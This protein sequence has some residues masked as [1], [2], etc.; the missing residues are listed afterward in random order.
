MLLLYLISLL[1]LLALAQPSEN[2]L[3]PIAYQL[4]SYQ[5]L[6]ALRM[7]NPIH[8][9]FTK[10]AMNGKIK[11][12]VVRYAD[13]G[14]KVKRGVYA[15]VEQDT[16]YL[17]SKNYGNGRHFVPV[18][19]QG[20]YCYFED[21]ITDSDA[22]ASGAMLGGAIGAGIA[23]A[24]TGGKEALILDLRNG[25][26]SIL[27]KKTMRTLL[28][29]DE[30][31]LHRYEQER[32]PKQA[33]LMREYIQDYN[34]RHQ[35]TLPDFA[36]SLQGKVVLYRRGKKER[37]ERIVITTSDSTVATLGPNAY[38]ELWVPLQEIQLCLG[39]DC[40]T[41]TPSTRQV[42]YLACGF[43]KKKSE[44]FLEVVEPKV[45]VFYTKQIK[46]LQAVE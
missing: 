8:A 4:G 45:G 9:S 5:T 39:T 7:H 25:R 21:V 42:S 35:H 43:P 1:P 30:E 3:T 19:D 23:G 44:A 31:L 37:E 26:Y 2:K 24:L 18:Q 11:R 41:L 29:D 10:R 14:K 36:T 32:Q 17:N 12:Y 46:H 28:A 33:T 40:V 34:E 22:I 20:V 38:Q 27:N 16:L 6:D 13:S 15:F